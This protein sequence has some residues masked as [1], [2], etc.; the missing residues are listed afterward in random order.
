MSGVLILLARRDEQGE[1][2]LP[3]IK[4]C[5]SHSG[6]HLAALVLLYTAESNVDLISSVRHNT[7]RD[8]LD[9]VDRLTL[10]YPNL[11][12]RIA[13]VQ[14][15]ILGLQPTPYFVQLV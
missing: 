7:Y 13:P 11:I 12:R 5:S 14:T 1:L 2:K 8:I 4:A 3:H 15:S 9:W 6:R 10:G